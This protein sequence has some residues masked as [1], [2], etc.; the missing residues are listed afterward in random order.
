MGI[1]HKH[2]WQITSIG[3]R[4]V[5]I[6]RVEAGDNRWLDGIL[7]KRCAYCGEPSRYII[8]ELGIKSECYPR[9]WGWCGECQIGG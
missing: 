9:V 4:E 2:K 8:T 1:P 3:N 5:A 7:L 6:K